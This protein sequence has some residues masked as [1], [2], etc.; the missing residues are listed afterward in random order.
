M[1]TKKQALKVVRIRPDV[2]YMLLVAAVKARKDVQDYASDAIVIGLKQLS[3]HQP[4]VASE[5]VLRQKIL[6]T[7]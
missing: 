1:K 2:H 3:R 5:A 4:D 6:S 7:I